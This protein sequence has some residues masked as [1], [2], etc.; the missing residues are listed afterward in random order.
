MKAGCSDRRLRKYVSIS[1]LLTPATT[2]KPTINMLAKFTIIPAKHGRPSQK[3]FK[4]KYCRLMQQ[5][6]DGYRNSNFVSREDATNYECYTNFVRIAG[7]EWKVVFCC[8][9]YK[10]YSKLHDVVVKMALVS[11]PDEGLI[12]DLALS[13]VSRE[14]ALEFSR[15]FMETIQWVK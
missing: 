7:Q 11:R 4:G 2:V 13:G 8:R 6:F 9:Q 15:R 5:E 10:K 12:A 1:Y 14:S 3:P